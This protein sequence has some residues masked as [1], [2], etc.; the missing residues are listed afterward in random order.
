M[1][2]SSK[3]SS[4]LW[5][6]GLMMLI[7]ILDLSLNVLE[8]LQQRSNGTLF[9]TG[10]GTGWVAALQIIIGLKDAVYSAKNTPWCQ[11][12]L[13]LNNI[14]V[15][16]ALSPQK[17]EIGAVEWERKGKETVLLFLEER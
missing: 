15:L 17:T 14:A 5:M 12:G 11:G 16:Y 4:G 3:P 2:Q 13:L 6:K 9:L 1:L 7:F 8:S 10:S